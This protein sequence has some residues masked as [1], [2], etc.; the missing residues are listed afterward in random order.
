[1][2]RLRSDWLRSAGAPHLPMLPALA[3]S[4][5]PTPLST[6]LI[7]LHSN[8]LMPESHPSNLRASR[9]S[10]VYG[11]RRERPGQVNIDFPE[12]IDLYTLH[13]RLSHRRTPMPC[14]GHF[15]ECKDRNVRSCAV[16]MKRG[17]CDM[18]NY[19]DL[20]KVNCPLSC[21]FCTPTE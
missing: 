1:M 12:L 14:R 8:D 21:K 17:H 16:H 9:L 15:Q 18:A 10:P 19:K 13:E 7:R 2:F 20:M 11:P 4:A 5:Y 3:T 6:K